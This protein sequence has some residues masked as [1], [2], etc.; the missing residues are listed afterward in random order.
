MS[1]GRHARGGRIARM[2]ADAGANVFDSKRL[3]Y[4][5]FDVLLDI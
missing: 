2:Q 4:G 5:G 3:I 1:S